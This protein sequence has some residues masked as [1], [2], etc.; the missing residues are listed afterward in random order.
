MLLKL[1]KQMTTFLKVIFHLWK[2]NQS[3][4]D[5]V[6]FRQNVEMQLHNV[7]KIPWETDIR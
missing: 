3:K 1:K 2:V 4:L 6:D 7:L 5:I